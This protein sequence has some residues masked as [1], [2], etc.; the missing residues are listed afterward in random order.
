MKD[1]FLAMNVDRQKSFPTNRHKKVNFNH[2]PGQKKPRND[3]PSH[4]WTQQIVLPPVFNGAY[5]ARFLLQ[6]L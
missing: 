3:G 4:N 2:K 6:I 1:G 5:A